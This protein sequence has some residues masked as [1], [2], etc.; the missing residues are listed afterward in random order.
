M[1]CFV[2]GVSD[3]MQKECNSAMLHENINISHIMVHEEYTARRKSRDAKRS[4]YF[5]GG[6]SKNRLDIHD[7]P[8]FKKRLSSQ[9]PSK[10]PKASGDRVYNPKFKKGKGNNSLTEKPTYGKCGK[11]HYGDILKETNNCFGCGKSSHKVM[12]RPNIRGQDKGW[13]KPKK[14]VQM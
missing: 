2:T 6:S 11:N 9:V 5:D 13:V 10:F 7:K 1:S 14:V 4:I 12:D 3:I 8:R